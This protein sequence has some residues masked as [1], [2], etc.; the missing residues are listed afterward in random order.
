M[1]KLLDFNGLRTQIGRLSSSGASFAKSTFDRSQ[2]AYVNSGFAKTRFYSVVKKPFAWSDAYIV[3]LRTEYL[4]LLGPNEEAIQAGMMLRD[5]RI[6]LIDEGDIG[7]TNLVFML[8]LSFVTIAI[9]WATF[10]QLDEIVRAEGMIVPPSSVQSIQSRLPGSVVEINVKLGDRV[11]RGDVLFR[12]EDQQVFANFDDNEITRVN[13]SAAVIRLEAE[14]AG[15]DTVV[16]PP[17]ML[18]A[19]PM[20]VENERKLF[21]QRKAALSDKL[22]V[23]ERNIAERRSE[24]VASRDMMHNLGQEISILEPLVEAGH[25][26]RLQLLQRKSEQSRLRGSFE[27]AKLAIEKGQDEYNAIVSEFKSLAATELAEVRMLSDQAGAHKEALTSQVG[28]AAIRAPLSGTVSAVYVKTLGAVV[29][30]GSAMAEILPD[31][32]AVLV[33]AKVRPEDISDVRIDQSANVALSSYDTARYGYLKGF[34]QQIASNTTQSE[35]EPPYYETMIE[36]PFPRFSKSE[37]DIEVVPGMTVTV[38]MIGNKRTIMNYILT[39]LERA[40]SVA[41]R[42]K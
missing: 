25:E 12:I 11:Q 41:F 39:P 35:T 27:Q 34:V 7:K 5:D 23:I 18:A 19:N 16:F 30:A 28:H 36:I 17:A 29:Q 15:L 42:E 13:S 2:D 4:R 14:I 10:T 40:S 26:S 20:A 37:A 31:E 6:E 32:Q 38:D 1:K 8:I 24:M 33:R 9:L 3:K 21:I 22:R